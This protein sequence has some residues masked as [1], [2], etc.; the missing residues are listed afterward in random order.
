MRENYP[1]W[2]QMTLKK[3]WQTIAFSNKKHGFVFNMKLIH[4]IIVPIRLVSYFM[5]HTAQWLVIFGMGV[6]NSCVIKKLIFLL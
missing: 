2:S 4:I 6:S 3:T 1:Y 5:L